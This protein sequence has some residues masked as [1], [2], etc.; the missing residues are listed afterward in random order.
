MSRQ[1]DA[2]EDATS[3]YNHDA[4]EDDMDA[5]LHYSAMESDDAFDGGDFAH[6]KADTHHADAAADHGYQWM[7][8]GLPADLV[9]ADEL[10]P[11]PF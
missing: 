11:C 7:L 6:V 1:F 2:Y 4:Y 5:F 3:S 9:T 10:Q 8:Q